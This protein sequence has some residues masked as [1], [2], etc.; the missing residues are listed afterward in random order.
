M[1]SL[2]LLNRTLLFLFFYCYNNRHSVVLFGLNLSE[3]LLENRQQLSVGSEL[4]LTQSTDETKRVFCLRHTSVVS[5][6]QLSWKN[7]TKCEQ[8]SQNNVLYDQVVDLKDDITRLK[9]IIN[10]MWFAPGG[11]A[12]QQAMKDYE[13]KRTCCRRKTEKIC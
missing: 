2:L 3:D 7:T 13:E 9:R 8:I 1:R 5:V 6:D 11:P 4:R 12:Y 10:H